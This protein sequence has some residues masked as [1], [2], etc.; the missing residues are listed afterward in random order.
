MVL[1]WIHIEFLFKNP[2]LITYIYWNYVLNKGYICS[3]LLKKRK[4]TAIY[5]LWEHI[6]DDLSKFCYLTVDE[7]L[8][9]HVVVP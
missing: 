6:E 2:H 5:S 7:F 4:S 8:F 1:L 9:Y 3:I